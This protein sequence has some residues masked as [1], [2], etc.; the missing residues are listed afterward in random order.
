MCSRAQTLHFDPS[1]DLLGHHCRRSSRVFGIRLDGGNHDIPARRRDDDHANGKEVENEMAIKRER[2]AA[3]D[4]PSEDG[5]A[6]YRA[7]RR[8]QRAQH[9]GEAVDGASLGGVYCVVN[10]Q[11]HVNVHLLCAGGEWQ[12]GGGRSE[13]VPRQGLS[14]SWRGAAASRSS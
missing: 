10:R 3:V 8:R 2:A 6:N 4:G 14:C 9:H 11:R 7:G 1:G 12:R 5:G 13:G